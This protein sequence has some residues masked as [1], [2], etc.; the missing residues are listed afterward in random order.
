M[1][2]ERRLRKIIKSHT[3]PSISFEDFC[4]R[5][6]ISSNE[7]VTGD[8]IKAK[9]NNKTIT[10]SLS[11]VAVC[12]C[13]IVAIMLVIFLPRKSAL[14]Y[15]SVDM[16]NEYVITDE[17]FKSNNVPTLINFSK[18][19][20]HDSILKAVPK[21][22]S[23]LILGYSIRKFYYDIRQDSI[24]YKFNLDLTIRCYKG[25][26]FEGNDNFN[27][28][29]KTYGDNCKYDLSVNNDKAYIYVTQGNYEYFI[30][31]RE[32][33]NITPL[34]KENIELLITDILS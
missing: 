8:G 33:E 7:I 17:Q 31:A 16:I 24:I 29:N 30:T 1:F 20:Q 25:Y 6:G 9:A 13:V 5:Q 34:T 22:G 21:D 11:I 15:F 19:E 3:K 26:L 12:L 10:I 27:N 23:N 14:R 28:L 32:Y 4:Q 2:E 18:V